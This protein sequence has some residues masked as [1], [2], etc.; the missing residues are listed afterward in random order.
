MPAQP[1]GAALRF[2]RVRGVVGATCAT[3]R[4][5]IRRTAPL[6]TV[7]AVGARDWHPAGSSPRG[8]TA[9]ISRA[10]LP[11]ALLALAGGTASSFG[12]L[13]SAALVPTR[14]MEMPDRLA[15]SRDP[16]F[17]TPFVRITEPGREILPGV[18]CSSKYCRHR[19]SSAQAWNADQTL[20]VIPK[21]CPGM[22][23]LDGQTYRPLFQRHPSGSCEWHPADPERMICVGEKAIYAWSVRSDTRTTL[24]APRHHAELKLGPGKANLS[25]DGSRLVVRATDAAGAQVVFAYDIETSTKYPDIPLASLAGIN[26]YCTISPSGRYIFCFQ[27]MPDKT[28]TGYVFTIDGNQ[29]QH[30]TENHRPGHGDMTIDS[31]GNDVYVGISKADP[32][33]YQVIKRRLADGAV[34][35][36]TPRGPA[37]HASVRNIRRPGWVFLTY[38]GSYESAA[39]RSD[40]LPVYQ[41]I[42]ALRIDGSGDMRRIAHTR[43]TTHDYL[44]EA[45]ASPSPDGSQVIWASNWGRP[46]G[47]VAAYVA[48]LSWQEDQAEAASQARGSGAN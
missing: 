28:Y 27:K 48:R 4:D 10:F 35:V 6:A 36:L 46:G 44:S 45:H 43:S 29:V 41:E 47:S 34:T 20:L 23:F 21:G 22:C 13:T 17:G 38:S 5:R 42:V 9:R 37:S 16:A 39:A 15:P 26:S 1:S 31:D 12:S 33:K 11:A 3:L 24:Y 2:A 8:R 7:A 19:Y 30:W 14:E 25:N 18:F 32:D 40:R